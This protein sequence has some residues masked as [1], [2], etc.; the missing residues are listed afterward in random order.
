[1]DGEPDRE[2]RQLPVLGEVVADDREAVAVTELDV[3]DAG[4]WRGRAKLLN[5]HREACFFLDGQ[6]LDRDCRPGRGP[7][8]VC[9]CRAGAY[10]SQRS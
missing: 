10:A 1:M 8:H 4:A 5:S 3:D 6:A 2:E 7:S 9:G